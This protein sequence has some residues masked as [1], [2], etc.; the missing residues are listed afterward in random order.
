MKALLRKHKVIQFTHSDG[1]RQQ[2]PRI[3]IS[4]APM[5]CNYEA[6]RYSDEIENLSRK[7]IERLRSDGEPYIALHLRYEKDMLAFTGCSHNLT[8]R[9]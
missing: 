6:L 7:L 9:I 5:P 1:A 4:K 8:K 3:V 2:R